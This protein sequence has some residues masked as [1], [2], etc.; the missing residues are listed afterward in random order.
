M[1]IFYFLYN[2]DFIYVYYVVCLQQRLSELEKQITDLMATRDEMQGK[3]RIFIFIM[4]SR[5]K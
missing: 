3:L 4:E 1:R 2:H 5:E